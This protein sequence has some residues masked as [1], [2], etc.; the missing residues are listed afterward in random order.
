MSSQ[1]TVKF[2][3][4]ALG[5]QGRSEQMLHTDQD[6][7]IVYENVSDVFKEETRVFLLKFA[8]LVN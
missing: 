7:A 1:P 4:L 5:S 2:A 6:N 3:W 8:A